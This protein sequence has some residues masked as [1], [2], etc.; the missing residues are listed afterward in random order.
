MTTTR[1]D[2]SVVIIGVSVAGMA[3]GDLLLRNGMGRIVLEKRPRTYVEQRQRAGTIDTFGV[4]MFRQWGLEEVLE[5]DSLPDH[6]GTFYVAGHA[7]PIDVDEDDNE[8]LF[9]P[10]QIL[11]AQPHR[12]GQRGHVRP[13]RLRR[14]DR[15]RDLGGFGRFPC[16]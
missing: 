15:S 14:D 7:I 6:E 9:C 5:D 2:A 8:S 3:L 10:Q 4:R 13:F 1:D 16:F 12:G 11:G